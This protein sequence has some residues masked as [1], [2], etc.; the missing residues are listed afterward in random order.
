MTIFNFFLLR[1]KV[2]NLILS[3]RENRYRMRCRLIEN[4]NSNY[5]SH[6]EASRLRD[7]CGTYEHQHQHLQDQQQNQQQEDKESLSNDSEIKESSSPTSS[8]QESSAGSSDVEFANLSSNDNLYKN[9]IIQLEEPLKM[10]ELMV[11]SHFEE[12]E[13]LVISSECELVTVTRVVSGRFEL[14]NKNIYFIDLSPRNSGAN[15]SETCLINDASLIENAN[16]SAINCYYSALDNQFA[17]NNL[18]HASHHNDLH[19]N[20]FKISLNQLRE[21]QL[22]RYNLRASALEIFLI[23]QSNFFLNFNK[24]VIVYF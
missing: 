7:Y 11:Q 14:T 3:S 13:K 17:F 5:D 9:S 2:A 16:N 12:K 20:D 24:E 15:T 8:K 18:S 21:V 1:P 19:Y 4:V 6:Y 10:N 22:R 23:D